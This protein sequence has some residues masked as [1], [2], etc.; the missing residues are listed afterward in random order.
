LGD[1]GGLPRAVLRLIQFNLSGLHLSVGDS[2][3]R[4]RGG[5]L[6]STCPGLPVSQIGLSLKQARLQFGVIQFHERLTGLDLIAFFDEHLNHTSTRAERQI[7]VTDGGHI[8]LRRSIRRPGL[9]SGGAG[10]LGADSMMRRDVGGA[11]ERFER[12]PV[13]DGLSHSSPRW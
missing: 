1:I 4:L 8:S 2:D 13:D 6:F 9:L 5:D 11:E 7:G 10:R 12:G 3:V